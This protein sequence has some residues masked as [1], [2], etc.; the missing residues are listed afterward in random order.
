MNS[1]MTTS[2]DRKMSKRIS[3]GV[4]ALYAA[5]I[6]YLVNK[7]LHNGQTVPEAVGSAL[8]DATAT[9]IKAI[10]F[11]AWYNPA[12]APVHLAIGCY[13]MAIGTTDDSEPEDNS[14]Q[15]MLL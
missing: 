1:S 8:G 4:T 2:T 14:V 7:H 3:E 13:N 9:L 12:T 5:G 6:V 11:V 15:K 10:G